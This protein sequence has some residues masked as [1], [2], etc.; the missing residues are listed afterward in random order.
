M[1]SFDEDPTSDRPASEEELERELLAS[2][3]LDGPSPAARE[4]AL[5]A[6]L[7]A[8]S[9]RR[10]SQAPIALSVAALGLAAAAAFALSARTNRE[11]PPEVRAEAPALTSSVVTSPPSP[12]ACPELVVGRGDAP[13]IATWEHDGPS[14]VAADGRSGTWLTF[15]DGTAKQNF[16][17]GAQLVGTPLAAAHSRRALH[18]RGGHFTKWGVAFGADLATGACYDASA[19]AGIEFSAKGQAALYVGVQVIDVQSPKFGG[20]CE[21]EPCYNSHRKRVVLDSSFKRYRV[22][23][24]ELAQLDSRSA[25]PL[26][27]KRIRFLEFSLRP[28]DTPFDFWL[29]DVAFIPRGE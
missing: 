15:D 16:A 4:R 21:H 27:L 8:L 6:G 2:G 12:R 22:R 11:R 1:T 17:N 19:Y 18:L 24:E 29:D 14:I 26:D 28:E 13:S 3:R 5:Q 9:S 25:F 7:L 10:P 20:F 23:W